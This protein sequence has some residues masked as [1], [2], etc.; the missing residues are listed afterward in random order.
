[1]THFTQEHQQYHRLLR[2]TQ[3]QNILNTLNLKK[4]DLYSKE[5]YEKFLSFALDKVRLLAALLE[6]AP[7]AS[8][9]H[10]SYIRTQSILIKKILTVFCA[11]STFH[12]EPNESKASRLKKQKNGEL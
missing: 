5:S 7:K 1:M 11:L 2:S 12:Y 8:K 4:E 9:Q 3:L 6:D 10:L